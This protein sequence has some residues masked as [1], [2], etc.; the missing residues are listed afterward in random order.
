MEH[1]YSD[2]IK[3]LMFWATKYIFDMCHTKAFEVVINVP[4]TE[5]I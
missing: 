1:G 4:L 3:L 5:Y 2:T